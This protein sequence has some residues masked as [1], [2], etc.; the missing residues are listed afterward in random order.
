MQ[1]LEQGNLPRLYQGNTYPD[2][3]CGI[4][5]TWGSLIAW[6]DPLGVV[7]DPQAEFVGI[8]TDSRTVRLGEVF[9]ALRGEHFDGHGFISQ[10]MAAG[11]AGVI[12]ECPVPYPHLLVADTLAAYQRLAQ[13]W[14]QQFQL[15]LIAITGSAGKTST[16]EMLAAA[17][18]RY[19]TVLKTEANHNNDIGV[20]QTLLRLG[21]QHTYA[22]VEMAM[23]GPGEIARLARMAQPTH[24][25]IT[26]IG[27]AH[28]GRLGSRQAIAQA[29]CELLQD[30]RGLAV[31]NG[32]DPLLLATAASVLAGGEY[33][34]YGLEQGQIRGQWDPQRQTVR[35][36][37]V[38]LPVPLPG[39]HQAMNWMGV[40]ATLISLGLDLAL[41][42]DPLQLPSSEMGR[43]RRLVLSQGRLILDETYNAAPEAMVA[44]LEL[45]AQTP[46][47]RR[48]A[49]LGPMR[50]LGDF[51]PQIYQQLGQTLAAL[52]LEQV[53]LLDPD[54]EMLGV[55][56]NQRFSCPPALVEF[57]LAQTQ[58][59]DVYLC[60]AAHAI[61]LDRVV[62]ELQ[63]AWQ[64]P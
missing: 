50:E 30:F 25:L 60:K 11:A 5:G 20:A 51:A 3:S 58:P 36:A 46:A 45:L 2:K 39:R 56:H 31:L 53:L 48:I 27:S 17:L 32:E 40:V 35:V 19:G 24:A 41:L 13:V 42:K 55:P 28:I 18:A 1:L 33:L 61:G 23:R 6:L 54:G 37:G 21:S 10:A 52:K 8:S 26:N 15:P 22:V 9:L 16:K 14:R 7:G 43:N 29:K 63:Q 44:A 47:G 4:Q 57:L 12:S 49:I 64:H 59:G 62:Q 34:T 38:E